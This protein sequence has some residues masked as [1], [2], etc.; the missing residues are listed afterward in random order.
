[1]M[2]DI[3]NNISLAHQEKLE[4]IFTFIAGL[5]DSSN[6]SEAVA[7]LLELHSADIAD[8]LDN[9]RDYYQDILPLLADSVKPE[10]LIWISDSNKEPAIEAFGIPATARM[11]EAL[12]FE[13]AI[14]VI[15]ALSP[16]LKE[17]ILLH[18]PKE[19]SKQILE[20]FTYPENTAGRIVQKNF[21]AL[22]NVWTVS[23]ALDMIRQAN[24]KTDFYA[25]I[26][27]DGRARPIGTILLSTLLK[28]PLDANVSELMN[29]ECMIA[30]T[31]TEVEEIAFLF[32][33]YALTI[34]PVVNKQ[35]K[36]VGNISLDSILYIIDEQTES[37]FLHLGGIN[38][39]D[40]FDD[41]YK[42]AKSRFPW[43]FI[44]LII[45][46][47]TCLVIDRFND[48]IAQIITAAT[49]M[50]IVASMGGNAGTQ[51]MTIT[52]HAISNR[53][54][55]AANNMRVITKEI[56]VCIINGLVLSFIG[57]IITYLLFWHANLSIVFA[58]SVLINFAFAGLLGSAIPIILNR[59]DIDP[60]A[61]SSVFLTAG[62]D[63]IGFFTFL[64]LTYAF[65]M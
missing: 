16:E 56:Y 17:E 47:I 14:E 1:M 23:Q 48:T 24:I 28:S 8:F 62:T 26:V 3:K 61:A 60:T 57:G 30:E 7:A 52:I 35:G 5:I 9:S 63:S 49:M 18:L 54:F 53:G 33:Q 6:L 36:L 31:H 39:S 65:L 15:E 40:I 44:N 27:A 4:E 12:D 29:K 19:K 13:D 32:K 22:K 34:V 25:L 51:V 58:S 38:N 41:L 10:V 21:I 43:L 45:A 64:A 55:S 46:C 37:D 59:F 11:I 42:T 50:P 20:G 2:Q